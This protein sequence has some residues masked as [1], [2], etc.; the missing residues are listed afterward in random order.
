MDSRGV[1][2][3]CPTARRS[4]CTLPCPLDSVLVSLSMRGK[5]SHDKFERTTS[6]VPLRPVV[7]VQQLEGLALARAWGFESP[8]PHHL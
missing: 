3:A 8:L 6:G 4:E 1:R 2:I 7:R 5:T